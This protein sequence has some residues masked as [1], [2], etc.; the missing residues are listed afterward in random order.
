M[1]TSIHLESRINQIYDYLYANS[2]VKIPTAIAKEVG[3][4]LRALAYAEQAKKQKPQIL[5]SDITKRN[6]K[7]QIRE[8]ASIVRDYFR[9]ANT[10]SR[11]Y[12]SESDI[13]LTDANVAYV[14]GKIADIQI[15]TTQRDV[16]GD[17][18]EIFRSHWAKSNGGQFFTDQRVTQLA[19][20]LL[21]FNPLK[22]DDFVDICAGTGGFL[23]AALKHIKELTVGDEEKSRKIAINAILGQEIDKELCEIAIPQLHFSWDFQNQI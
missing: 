2:P 6:D 15:T 4:I 7:E 11:Y 3:K 16:F 10:K 19:I 22:G 5:S 8:I 20:K 12:E 13:N 18:M 1:N 14:Y 21:Q 23:I 9:Q 17:A